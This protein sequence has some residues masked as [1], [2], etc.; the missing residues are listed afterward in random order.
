MSD[1]SLLVN[2]KTHSAGKKA[3]CLLDP[4]GFPHRTVHV[5]KQKER[6]VMLL[7]EI[8]MRVLAIGAYSNHFC[9]QVRERFVGV[10]ER[11]SFRGA[12]A[13]EVFR[14]EINDHVL[15]SKKILQSNVSAIASRYAGNLLAVNHT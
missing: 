13:G 10:P 4:I 15:L 12:A 5:T 1:N 6:Q 3:E 9:P 8:S 14:I 2:H 7:S 11:A